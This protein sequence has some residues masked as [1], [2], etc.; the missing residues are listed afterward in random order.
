[1]QSSYV[2][3]FFSED[4]TCNGL[5]YK[6]GL[7]IDPN[8]SCGVGGLYY[9]D[10]A[11]M[12][13]YSNYGPILGFVTIPDN[14]PIVKVDGTQYKSPEIFITKFIKFKD[15]IADYTL[16][17]LEKSHIR[18]PTLRSLTMENPSEEVQLAA[19]NKNGRYIDCIKGPSEAVQLAAVKR[20]GES[21]Q[22]IKDPSEAVQLAAVK[23]YG[24]SI[25]FI[26]DPSEAVQ[27]AAVKE[28]G[29]SM[30]FIED[31]SENVQL[32]AVTRDGGSIMHVDNPSESV[33]L[34]AVNQY[35]TSINMINSQMKSIHKQK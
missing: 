1:V 20:N 4:L 16:D 3:K 5:K 27:I 22:F 10:F 32:A 26:K 17:L 13:E 2:K 34:A 19:V 35:G 8:P 23:E 6:L 14:V 25:E 18:D 31:P 12:A 21:I 15:W 28:D 30:Q 24:W 9:T 33:K 29:D 11:N 7:N